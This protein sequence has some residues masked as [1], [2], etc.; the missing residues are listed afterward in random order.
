MTAGCSILEVIICLTPA[1]RTAPLIAILSAS[2]PPE[3]KNISDGEA[4]NK[5]AIFLLAISITDRLFLP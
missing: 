5:P 3:V 2:V 4:F 1:S